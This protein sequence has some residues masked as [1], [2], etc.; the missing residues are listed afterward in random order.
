MPESASPIDHVSTRSGASRRPGV[1]ALQTRERLLAVTA[2]LLDEVPFKDLTTAMV[3]Q[4]LDLSPP[5]FY[6]YFGD[7]TDALAEC[8]PTMRDTV[9]AIAPIVL[10]GTWR[11]SRAVESAAVVIDAL[12][13][14]WSRHRALYRVT[15]LLADEGDQRFADAKHHTFEPLTA[16]FTEVMAATPGRDPAVAAGV[17][18]ASVVHVTARESG[19]AA[20][21]IDRQTLRHHLALQVATIVTGAQRR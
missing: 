14:F 4:R 10:A 8:A 5:A 11:G 13:D 21:G 1:R 12:A 16:A 2:E 3:T 15:D 18:V 19:F 17:V 7:I 20:S 9:E 6:R